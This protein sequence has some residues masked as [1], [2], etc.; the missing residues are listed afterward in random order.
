MARFFS[1]DG[2]DARRSPLEVQGDEQSTAS[3]DIP[4]LQ[5]LS[6]Q[7]LADTAAQPLPSE[8]RELALQL[9]AA[10]RAREEAAED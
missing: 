8:L 4:L 3:F 6:T 9:A 2:H 10:L 7:V 1:T 5:K